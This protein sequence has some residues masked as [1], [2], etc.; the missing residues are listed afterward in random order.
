QVGPAP[1]APG[2]NGK[3]CLYAVFICGDKLPRYVKNLR[4]MYGK[5]R[6]CGYKKANISVYYADGG[7]LDL[8]GDG[9]SDVT[10]AAGKA[11]F[12]A[13]LQNLCANLNPLTDVLFIYTTNHGVK[14][15]G[16]HL[17]LNAGKEDPYTPA[18]FANDTKNCKACRV[19]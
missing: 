14:N 1:P 6:A 17:P 19:F 16:L 7:A 11:T 8:D 18:E 4:S 5:L 15:K 3:D 9:N 2:G 10:G 12:R 13:K